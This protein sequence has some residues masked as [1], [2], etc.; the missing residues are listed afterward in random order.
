MTSV[1]LITPSKL[2]GE[3]VLFKG[4]GYF[5]HVQQ[6]KIRIGTES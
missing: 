4:H 5:Y 6:G 3:F 1:I 2:T